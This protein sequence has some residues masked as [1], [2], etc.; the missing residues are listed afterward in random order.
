ME[1]RGI[2]A[3]GCVTGAPYEDL[4]W[5]PQRAKKGDKLWYIWARFDTFLGRLREP[6]LAREELDKGCLRHVHWDTQSSGITIPEDAAGELE[7]RWANFLGRP[8]GYILE[9]LD[10]DE[11]ATRGQRRVSSI[12]RIARDTRISRMVKEH[13]GHQCQI[14]GTTLQGPNGLYSESAHI[15]PLG[16]GHNGPDHS[17]NILCLCPNHHVLFDLGAFSVNDDFTLV[18]MPGSLDVQP[19][20]E[21]DMTYLRYHRKHIFVK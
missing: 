12:T 6:I 17:S 2:M 15:Q 21:P 14:C 19:P 5:N 20:Y 18:G 9:T 8:E 11:P 3:S 4:H 10:Q 13:Y 1:P 7:K 16:K